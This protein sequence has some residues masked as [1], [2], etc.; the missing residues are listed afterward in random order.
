MSSIVPQ[1]PR[2]L[3]TDE[4]ARAMLQEMSQIISEPL[5]I[6]VKCEQSGCE[7]ILNVNVPPSLESAAP[8]RLVVRCAACSNLL[9]VELPPDTYTNHKTA[10]LHMLKMKQEEYFSAASGLGSS[11]GVQTP[12]QLTGAKLDG[13]QS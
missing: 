7:A 10:Q 13:Q 1:R 3:V 8:P 9:K 6:T 5:M 4:R 11:L 2:S 12:D